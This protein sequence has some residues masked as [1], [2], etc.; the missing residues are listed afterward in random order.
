MCPVGEGGRLVDEGTTE[1]NGRIPVNPSGGL[2]ARGHPVA[3]TG[4][5]QLAEVVWQ[6]RGQAGERQ[7]DPLPRVGL[8]QNA[9][10][11]AD[12]EAAASTATILTR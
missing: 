10:G 7:I 2:E 6:L 3:A 8:A 11:R 4:L 9:G 1:I 5:A 12:G